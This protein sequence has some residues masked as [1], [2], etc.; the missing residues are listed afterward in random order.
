M[1]LLKILKNDYPDKIKQLHE[2]LIS[3]MGKN[4]LKVLKK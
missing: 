3:Y 4:D 2:A 1:K